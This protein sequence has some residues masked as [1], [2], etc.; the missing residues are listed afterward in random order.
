VAK[1]DVATETA[2]VVARIEQREGANVAR[3]APIF[4]VEIMKMEIPVASPAD[5][6][7]VELLVAEGDSVAEGQRVAVIETS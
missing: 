5:G 7:I 3:D 6:T 4:F 1:I 2:G